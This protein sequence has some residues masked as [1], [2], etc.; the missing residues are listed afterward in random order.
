MKLFITALN[1]WALSLVNG[2]GNDGDQ[3]GRE[4]RQGHIHHGGVEIASSILP[5]ITTPATAPGPSPPTPSASSLPRQVTAAQIAS[6]EAAIAKAFGLTASYGTPCVLCN[7][8]AAI[9]GLLRMAFH[10]AS[11]IGT[12]GPLV[13]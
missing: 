3:V 7:E 11:G 2:L 4:L 13:C 1:I 8:G 12:V 10:D 9:G 5:S 6:L